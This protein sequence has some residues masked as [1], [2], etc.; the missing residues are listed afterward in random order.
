V[1]EGRLKRLLKLRSEKKKKR[2]EEGK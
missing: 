1:K 2:R